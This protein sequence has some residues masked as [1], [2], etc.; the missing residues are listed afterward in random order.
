LIH[1]PYSAVAA[2]QQQAPSQY[3]AFAANLSPA[4][5]GKNVKK[6]A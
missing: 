3:R 2:S 4:E 1:H 5:P 6:E